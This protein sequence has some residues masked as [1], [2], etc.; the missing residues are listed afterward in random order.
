MPGDYCYLVAEKYDIPVDT[1]MEWNPAV[2][3]PSCN[4][5]QIDEAYCVA[6]GCSSAS[7]TST[8]LTTS[9]T[10]SAATSTKATTTTST[11]A[12]TSTTSAVAYKM[13]TG[14]GTVAAGWPSLSD[15]LDFDTL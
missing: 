9:T 10:G 3:A 4:N 11:S 8:T 14:N 15:W 7:S 12:A 2:N 1:F 6:V 5:M 13:Y